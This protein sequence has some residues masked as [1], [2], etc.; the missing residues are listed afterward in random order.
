MNPEALARSGDELLTRAL[1]F[2]RALRDE[3][4][5]VTP[6]RVIDALRSLE[7]V[8]LE[9]SD[10]FRLAL[11]VNLVS[12]RE[13]E[14]AFERAFDRFWHS[15]GGPNAYVS[16]NARSELIRG[17]LREGVREAHPEWT[18]TSTQ[19]SPEEGAR[20]PEL[21]LRFDES[22]PPIDDLARELA[23]RLATRPSRRERT[24]PQGNRIDL[25]HSLRRNARHGLEMLD[26]SFRERR[27]RKT[28]LV[29]LS[30]VSGSMD[31]YNP[32]L[33]Q[34]ML[35]LSKALPNSR[36]LVFSTRVTEI[37]P[38]L[39]Q[40]S[41]A[42][43]LRAIGERV[44]HWSGGTDIGSAL[45]ELN[46]GV[47]REGSARS[48]VAVVISDGYDQGEAGAIEGEMRALRRRV[49]SVAWI[50]PMLGSST[51]QP[52]AQGMRAALPHVD[53]FLPAWDVPSLRVLV[54]NLARA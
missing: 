26:L 29:M 47:L 38:L 4:L 14:E 25:R 21:W 49:R 10:E 52:T 53:Y 41:V 32:F 39:R 24:A 30:D 46:R 37:S 6:A 20:D 2:C 44:R 40:R 11:R 18:H 43:T 13:Q 17:S 33:L 42:Q 16:L 27:L 9:R 34:L 31:A 45:A 7:R 12:S 35:G 1:A 22:A 48:T 5:P 23:R 36:T 51:Y 8:R 28:R 19:W 3:R 50:N 15:V 54:R